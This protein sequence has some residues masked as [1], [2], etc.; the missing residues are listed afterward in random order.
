MKL[1]SCLRNESH[2]YNILQFLSIS[3]RFTLTVVGLIYLHTHTRTGLLAD[4]VKCAITHSGEH[5]LNSELQFVCIAPH[6]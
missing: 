4:K 1:T 6:A 2:E 3:F 5:T